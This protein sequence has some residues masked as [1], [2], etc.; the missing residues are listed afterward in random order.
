MEHTNDPL[1]KIRHSLAH[2]LAQAVLQIRPSAKLAFGP[3]I[4]NGCYYDFLFT[5]PLTPENFADIEK[6]MRKIIAERQE[7]KASARAA[8]DAVEHLNKLGQNFKAEYCEELISKGEKEIG[9][10]VNGTFED[11]CAGPHVEHTGQIPPDCFKLDSI[12]GAYWRGSE[13][14]PQL[15][16]LYCL[17]FKNKGDLEAYIENRRLAQERDHRKLGKEL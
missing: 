13:K 10:Y 14:N 17:A 4:D 1:Y 7:F 11:M 15:S 5:E 12:A 2:V 3:P 8:R 9:F 16:R 6:R